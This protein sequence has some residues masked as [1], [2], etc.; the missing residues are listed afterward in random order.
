MVSP[1]FRAHPTETAF[2]DGHGLL[3]VKESRLVAA[4]EL[5]EPAPSTTSTSGIQS[6]GFE[7]LRFGF[8]EKLVNGI[9]RMSWSLHS[10]SSDEPQK[11]SGKH[12]VFGAYLPCPLL[13]I[14]VAR[15][16]TLV[17]EAHHVNKV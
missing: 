2:L 7:K 14:M 8:A 10:A 5:G 13:K 4:P 12:G 16:G 6:R 3:S 15:R 11:A 9:Q 1:C 17:W